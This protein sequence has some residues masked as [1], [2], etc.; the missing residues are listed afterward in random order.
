MT[1]GLILEGGGAR[2]A[3]QI[4]A[5]AAFFENATTFGGVA[6]SSIGALN[7]AMIAQ[8][9]WEKCLQWWEKITLSQLF[10]VDENVLHDILTLKFDLT[11]FDFAKIGPMRAAL[12]TFFENK[13]L[14]T[15]KIRSLLSDVFDE[16]KLRNSPI[17]FGMITLKMHN[18]KPI[19]LFK[20]DIPEGMLVEYLM[21]SANMPVFKLEPI[22]GEI[23]LDGGFYNNL[24]INMLYRKGFRDLLVIRTYA[25]GVIR[26]FHRA[27]LHVTEIGP[28]EDLGNMLDFSH[29]RV[30]RSIQIGRCDALRLIKGL[31]GQSYYIQN[32]PEE[33]EFFS[34]FT[35]FENQEIGL[36]T[37]LMNLYEGEPK[38]LLFEKILPAAA[39]E[40]GLSPSVG[41]RE[42]TLAVLERRAKKN[43]IE[44]LQIFN[45]PDFV[46]SVKDTL[47]VQ[48][49]ESL[50][51]IIGEHV[52]RAGSGLSPQTFDLFS[53]LILQK[54]QLQ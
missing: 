46:N 48:K 41:Y 8:G 14:D 45:Y 7:G 35:A 3:Y 22:G 34:L 19:E 52:K 12:H 40:L 33:R 29:E 1:K 54:I 26:R 15:T 21:A 5:V 36:L 24:P 38:R 47:A 13:G 42:I 37:A 11:K 25:P 27:D 4:G 51:E 10:D 16:E 44:R 39:R 30:M 23:Y 18:L 17:D 6:G 50:S 32:P 53:D 9:D 43:K 31:S 2:G 49:P 28:S 20:E